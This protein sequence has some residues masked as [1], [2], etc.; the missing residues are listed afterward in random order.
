MGTLISLFMLLLSAAY[1]GPVRAGQHKPEPAYEMTTYYMVFLKRGP[2]WTRESTPEL[3]QLQKDHVANIFSLL[4]SGKAVAGGPFLDDGNIGGILILNVGS[5][6]EAHSLAETD[7][8]VKVGRLALEIHPWFAARGI[9][10]KPES[11]SQFSIYHVAFLSRGP[12]W[13]PEETPE[14]TKLQAAH[15]AN[16]QKMA[17]AGKLVIAGP[18]SD[19]GQLRGV[20]VFK[21]ES[22][23]EA[24]KLAEADPAVVAGRLAA[25]V[26]PWM[27]PKGTLP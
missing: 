5:A 24:R 15:M 2:K 23:D 25:E 4:E 13:T 18:F 27:V 12:K 17:A 22:L 7:P 9:M 14:T 3:A 8:M 16:I 21:T 10:K 1:P 19:N 6:E 20:F 11:H 26:H